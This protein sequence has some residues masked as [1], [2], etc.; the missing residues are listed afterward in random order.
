M[1][2]SK[3]IQRTLLNSCTRYLM[4]GKAQLNLDNKFH[5][6]S[7]GSGFDVHR[8]WCSLRGLSAFTFFCFLKALSEA[9][10]SSE[11]KLPKKFSYGDA[12]KEASL[13]KKKK[14]KKESSPS[15]C[16]PL[17]EGSSCRYE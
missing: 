16:V 4:N 11:S 14:T 10:S 7:V 5:V 6:G 15:S 3:R 1:T 9:G 8:G 17:T 13:F 2:L 12:T